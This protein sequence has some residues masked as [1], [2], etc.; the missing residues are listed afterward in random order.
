M[1]GATPCWIKSLPLDLDGRCAHRTAVESN[2]HYEVDKTNWIMLGGGCRRPCSALSRTA[3]ATDLRA[4]SACIGLLVEFTSTSIGALV[5]FWLSERSTR[6]LQVCIAI[7][8]LIDLAGSVG[9]LGRQ[10]DHG[11]AE[12]GLLHLQFGESNEW[13]A[14]SAPLRQRIAVPDYAANCCQAEAAE[15]VFARALGG[16]PKLEHAVPTNGTRE[17]TVRPIAEVVEGRRAGHALAYQ[18]TGRSC[19]AGPTPGTSEETLQ[20]GAK[21]LAWR[22]SGQA[23]TVC[24]S[25]RPFR[26]ARCDS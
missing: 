7:K 20:L 12:F 21:E 13:N 17:K 1:I 22:R 3:P 2:R 10:Q 6:G 14:G 4:A 8:S 16:T 11:C 24:S 19:S 15:V 26:S 18:R 23:F 25:L 5:V 9:T